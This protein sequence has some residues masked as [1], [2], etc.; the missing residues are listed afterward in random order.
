MT[1]EDISP[2]FSRWTSAAAIA[3]RVPLTA[4]I[5]FG[6]ALNGLAVR[7]IEG[8]VNGG[9]TSFGLGV[10]PFV[11]IALAVAARFSFDAPSAAPIV[12]AWVNA[13]ALTMLLV[14]SSA[15]SWAVVAGYAAVVARRTT[16]RARTGALLFLAMGLTALWSSVALKWLATPITTAE[17]SLVTAVV[18]WLRPDIVQAGNVIGN[19]ETHSLVLMSACTTADALPNAALAVVAV[20]VFLGRIDGRRLGLALLGLAA[21]YAAAN[22]LRL[23]A[24]AWSADH[25]AFVHGP[26]GANIFDLAQS[27]AVLALG[28]WVART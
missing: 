24:M 7:L 27:A 19:P 12:P 4:V 13:L 10:G 20:G 14:P 5:M 26:I 2:A 28:N 15:I 1:A 18:G 9:A 23:A 22:T 25:Y 11:L 6:G 3:D 21:G 16:D 17:A 8:M